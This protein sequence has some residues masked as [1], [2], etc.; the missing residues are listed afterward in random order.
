M[1]SSDHPDS[2]LPAGPASPSA[3]QESQP[4]SQPSSSAP[5]DVTNTSQAEN[6]QHGTTATSTQDAKPTVNGENAAPATSTNPDATDAP[7]ADESQIGSGDQKVVPS[8]VEK[9]SEA[10]DV[11]EMEDAGPPLV[12][13]LLLTT[14]AR[15]P[16][17]IDSLYLRKRSVNVD[18]CDPF[19]MSVY[20]LKELIWREWRSDWESRPA[21]PSSIRLISFGKLLEDK[22]PLADSKFSCDA[23]N[24]VH[25]TVKPQEM[26]EEEDAKGTKAQYN[27]ER[28]TNER[29]PACRCI[30]L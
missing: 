23:P 27:R 18:N 13:T 9:M 14:G 16:F 30:I 11:K 15:H 2:G 22:S 24:V 28:D 1:S 25:M 4:L 29:S 3:P 20:T 10:S 6:A 21:S 7:S 19:A 12:I 17:K 8:A 5:A 26:I